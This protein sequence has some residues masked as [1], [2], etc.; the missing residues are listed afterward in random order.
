MSKFPPSLFAKIRKAA[1]YPQLP[2]CMILCALVVGVMEASEISSDPTLK[3]FVDCDRCDFDF[4]RREIPFVHY[5]R[6]RQLA[7]V[8]IL[9][10]DQRTGS[11]GREFRLQFIGQGTFAGQDGELRYT[12]QPDDT[13]DVERQGLVKTLQLGL[14]P[15]IAQTPLASQI[16]I[17]YK[18][19]SAPEAVSQPD[20]PWNNWIFRIGTAGEFE[21]ESQTSE[22]SL[23]V[24]LSA[25]RITEAWKIETE[26]ELDYDED[27]FSGDDDSIEA[28]TNEAELRTH[29]VRSI[30]PHW[31]AGAF[32]ATGATTR[33]NIDQ[34]ILLMP[35]IEYSL[36][37]YEH[38]DQ[39]QLTIAYGIGLESVEYT[40][41]T[42]FDKLSERLLSES[43]LV[44]LELTQ[45][46]GEVELESEFSHY[47]HDFSKYR[48]DLGGE[49]SIR[50]FKGL[51]F[52]AELDVQQIHDQLY[53]PKG[54]APL[55]EVILRRREL[56]TTFEHEGRI[57]FRYTFGSIYNNIINTR[58]EDLEDNLD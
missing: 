43:L 49:V 46:W 44:T 11:G 40:E 32:A 8:H 12:S 21:R 56:A 30:N 28:I 16:S 58:L 23:D 29:V 36:F 55:Q 35:A 2:A 54:G 13:E 7:Q 20:D 26:F 39:K 6:D 22:Y 38:A 25:K 41:E 24:D 14:M 45:R 52:V 5:V 33:E 31:S 47:F 34:Q 18:A 19:A 10:T 42:I 50:L 9:V 53:L 57:G 48:I 1:T 17:D 51:E 3:V 27:T 37:R 15:Y 4:L